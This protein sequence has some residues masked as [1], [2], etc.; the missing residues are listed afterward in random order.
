MVQTLS[1]R[2]DSIFLA[3]LDTLPTPLQTER[4][5]LA[6]LG[7]QLFVPLPRR[8]QLVGWLA[9]GS[10]LSGETYTNQDLSYLV[11][12]SDQAA[13]AIERAQ[14]IADLER[15]VRRWLSLHTG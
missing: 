10:R 14:V 11:S 8:L 2:R 6:L 5:H 1:V 7:S 9:L 4:A 12:L 13:L 3:G 15:R